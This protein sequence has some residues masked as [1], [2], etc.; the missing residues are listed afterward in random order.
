MDEEPVV[1]HVGG[2]NRLCTFMLGHAVSAAGASQDAWHQTGHS[3][4][5]VI[6]AGAAFEAHLGEFLSA[7]GFRRMFATELEDWRDRPPRPHEVLKTILKRLGVAD[8][9]LLKWYQELR[10]LFELRNHIAHYYPEPRAVGTFPPKL[11]ANC[12]QKKIIEPAGDASMD[13]TSRLFIAPVAT[14]AAGIALSA[15]REFD[16][17][18]DAYLSAA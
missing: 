16:L 1:G 18:V 7:P 4:V 8:V 2:I 5:A 11:E 17:I 12:I 14:Q 6:L 13:W 10:C 15:I 9:S 3:I